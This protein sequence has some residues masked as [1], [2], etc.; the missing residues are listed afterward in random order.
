[1]D[2][3]TSS[4]SAILFKKLRSHS[5][6]SFEANR[7]EQ[8]KLKDIADSLTSNTADA[9]SKIVTKKSRFK[10][11]QVD[12]QINYYKDT[13][14]PVNNRNLDILKRIDNSRTRLHPHNVFKADYAPL[15]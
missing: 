6:I 5:D 11:L 14:K 3:F 13:K 9:N 12:T 8:F 1:M 7:I 10:P 2:F 4:K 15:D